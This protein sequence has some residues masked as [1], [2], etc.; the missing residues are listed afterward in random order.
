[1]FRIFLV[2]DLFEIKHNIIPVHIE[3]TSFRFFFSSYSTLQNITPRQPQIPRTWSDL[4]YDKARIRLLNLSLGIFTVTSL[5]KRPPRAPR[6]SQSEREAPTVVVVLQ[7]QWRGSSF[8]S[9]WLFTCT[10]ECSWRMNKQSNK[11]RPLIRG[12]TMATRRQTRRR[13]SAALI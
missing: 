11:P 13:S 5:R 6:T 7:I 3:Y 12:A 8:F 1:M 9:P 10:W 2:V 4:L